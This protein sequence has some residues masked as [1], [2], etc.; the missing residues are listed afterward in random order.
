MHIFVR[1]LLN[2]LAGIGV[3]ALA[4]LV[5]AID[6]LPIPFIVI[7]AILLWVVLIIVE[8][9]THLNYV[10]EIRREERMREY[11]KYDADLTNMSFGLKENPN[12]YQ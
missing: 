7:V 12:D 4:F 2:V 10:Q 11:M 1:I 9:R 8:V 5:G 6:S 3:T